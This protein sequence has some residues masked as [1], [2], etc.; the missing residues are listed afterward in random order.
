M[1]FINYTSVNE[2]AYVTYGLNGIDF[3]AFAIIIIVLLVG[4][5][6]LGAREKRTEGDPLQNLQP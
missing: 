2:P 4:V 3:A 6:V 1:T 5:I